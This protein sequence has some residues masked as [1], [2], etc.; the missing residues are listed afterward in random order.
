MGEAT[1]WLTELPRESINSWEELTGVFYETFFPPSEMVKL[2]DNIQNFKRIDGEPIYETWLREDQVSAVNFGLSKEQMQKNQERDENMAK[3]ISQIDLLTKHVMVSGHKVVHAVVTNMRV[4]P[5]D[6]RFEYKHNDKVK[7]LPSHVG[8][9]GGFLSELSKVR[10]ESRLERLGS[11]LGANKGKEVVI[12]GD[13]LTKTL[14]SEVLKEVEYAPKD[15]ISA[16]GL[17]VRQG[18]YDAKR[19]GKFGK[20]EEK[21]SKSSQKPL[22]DSPRI[23]ENDQARQ[24]FQ[25]NLMEAKPKGEK[26]RNSADRRMGRRSQ[27]TLPN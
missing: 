25:N 12:D 18:H 19:S 8:E 11:R 13:E 6:V 21:R 1:K 26:K 10:R 20:A 27:L 5:G 23:G 17:R 2:R 16:K 3:M 9:G 4:S 14:S 22:G 15:V 24:K 7:F